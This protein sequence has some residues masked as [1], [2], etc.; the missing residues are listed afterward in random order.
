MN[1]RSHPKFG[2]PVRSV[3]HQTVASA[4]RGLCVEGGKATLARLKWCTSV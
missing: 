2:K 3:E 1:M 4:N